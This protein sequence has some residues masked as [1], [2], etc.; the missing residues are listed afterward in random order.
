MSLDTEK[1]HRLR[2]KSFDALYEAHPDKW[3]ETV[4]NALDYAQKCVASGE[5]VRIGDVVAIFQNAI[6]I[7]PTFEKHTKDKGLTQKYWVTWF[8]EYII[9][10]VYPQ[11]ELTK[12]R[13]RR[14]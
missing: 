7:D 11:P 14:T 12:R 13:P 8:A 4:N 3:Q 10:R 5:K 1:L 6:R 9:D 2:G